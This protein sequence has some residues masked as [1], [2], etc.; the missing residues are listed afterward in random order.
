MDVFADWASRIKGRS[1]RWEDPRKKHIN[2]D[3]IEFSGIPYMILGWR[4]MDCCCA[5]AHSRKKVIENCNV[6]ASVCG[7]SKL[8]FVIAIQFYF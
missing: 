4:V 1:V 6:N 7:D 5:V 8:A 3:S 2:E